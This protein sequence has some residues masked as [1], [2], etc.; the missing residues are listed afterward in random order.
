MKLTSWLLAAGVFALS[1]LDARTWTSADGVS[2]F[3][4][5][6][7]R[8]HADT[9]QVTVTKGF[10]DVTFRINKLSESDQAWVKEQAEA[11]NSKLTTDSTDL[12]DAQMIGSK[13]KEGVLSK[14]DDGEFV[15]YVMTSAPDYYV[16]YYSGSW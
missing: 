6:F 14:L 15:D 4:G 7:V 16:V 11:K 2:T 13:L 1:P 12:L 10:R 8:Y 5:D 3:S 9:G